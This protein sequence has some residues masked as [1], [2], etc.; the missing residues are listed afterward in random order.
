MFSVVFSTVFYSGELSQDCT[1]SL[2]VWDSQ[3]PHIFR[4]TAESL[5]GGGGLQGRRVMMWGCGCYILYQGPWRMGRAYYITRGGKHVL[6]FNRV[7]SVYKE[8]CGLKGHKNA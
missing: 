8:K 7:G 5:G 6:P 3:E 4:T 1:G 2:V